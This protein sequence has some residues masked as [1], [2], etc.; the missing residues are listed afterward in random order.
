MQAVRLP[1][2]G[3]AGP[4]SGRSAGGAGAQSQAGNTFPKQLV[5]VPHSWEEAQ[6]VHANSHKQAALFPQQLVLVPH[7]QGKVQVVQAN[8]LRQT[9][10][11][12]CQEGVQ[13]VQALSPRQ[14]VPFALNKGGAQA[15]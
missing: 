11:T 7:N 9:A 3:S 2:A 4:Q 5:L 1:Q 8:F 10:L 15:V 13:A 12:P 14:A 6:A